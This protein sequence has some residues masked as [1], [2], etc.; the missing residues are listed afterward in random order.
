MTEDICE[1]MRRTA[2]DPKRSIPVSIMGDCPKEAED[3]R[4]EQE[5]RGN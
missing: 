5:K 2:G 1:E 3:P 4:S